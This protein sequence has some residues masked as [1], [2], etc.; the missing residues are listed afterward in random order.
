MKKTPLLSRKS[1]PADS[2]TSAVI[3]VDRLLPAATDWLFECDY[4]GASE[5]TVAKYRTIAENLAWFLRDR[6]YSRC[7]KRELME[8]FGYVRDGHE[9]PRGRWGNEH[10]RREARPSTVNTYFTVVRTL[11]RYLVLEGHLPVS[12]VE[13]MKRPEFRQDQV[14]PFT[15]DEVQRLRAAAKRSRHP[16]RDE[17]IVLLLMDTDMRASELC[18]LR[19]ADL[20]MNA[21]RCRI[22]HGKGNKARSVHFGK[23]TARALWQYLRELGGERGDEAPI[24]VSDRG[25]GAGNALTRSGLLQLIE[26]LG[27]AAQVK[28]TRCS[29]HTF[30]HTFAIEFLRSGAN[31]FSLKELL[32][33]TSL[34]ICNQYVALAAADLE[35]Q[36]RQHSPVDRLRKIREK[37]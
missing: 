33:H 25:T 27:E 9:D 14:Q 18:D 11:F 34:T 31:V 12:P 2:D 29:P 26:R 8:F 21:R 1:A 17:A 5:A 24:F 36:H 10:N 4:G 13:T 7:G 22:T 35:Q 20:D 37:R 6:E 23:D 32:G 28:G 3:P 19:M 16:R 15:T 30:R